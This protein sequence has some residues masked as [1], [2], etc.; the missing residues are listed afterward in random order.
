MKKVVAI[1][2]S[3]VGLS[4]ASENITITKEMAD[5]LGKNDI[6]KLFLETG[7]TLVGATVSA[8]SFGFTIRSDSNKDDRVTCKTQSYDADKNGFEYCETFVNGLKASS[9]KLNIEYI[10]KFYVD[11]VKIHRNVK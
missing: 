5:A 9:K 10:R 6:T 2:L 7:N 4:F 3:L 1:A 11:I 8:T